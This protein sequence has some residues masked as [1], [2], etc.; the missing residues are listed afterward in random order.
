MKEEELIDEISGYLHIYL[1]SGRLHLNSFVKKLNTNVTNIQQLLLIRLLLKEE[2]K[3]FVCE[4]P[5]LLKYFKT[6]TH[7]VRNTN[8]GEVRGE[9]DWEQT[10]NK[11][12]NTNYKDTLLYVTT[13]SNRSYDTSENLVLKKLL[14]ILYQLTYENNYIQGFEQT[15]WFNDWKALK[16]HIEKALREN[17]YIQRVPERFVSE[18][19][20]R[21]T[22]THRYP[23][24]R[25]AAFILEEYYRIMRGD[26][27]E[28]ELR[29]LLK[30]TF[31]L[32]NNKDVLFELY[33]IIKIIKQN[34]GNS[35]LYLLDG[36]ENLVA[37]WNTSGY[38]YYI[39]HD[40]TGSTDLKFNIMETELANSD[41]PYT[42]QTYQSFQKANELS[43]LL[44]D[45]KPQRIFR[46][47]RPDFIIEI[48]KEDTGKLVH[49][50][51]GEVKNTS[52]RNY[53]MR[54]MRELLDYIYLVQ[55]VKG[56]Y[57]RDSTLV[58][59]LLCVGDTEWNRHKV[60]Q[61]LI[62]IA[63]PGNWKQINL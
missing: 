63:S 10:I 62:K 52:D 42:E 19:M 23:L 16:R 34:T 39:Y 26:Y 27:T 38:R 17:I 50:I 15:E 37:S 5:T 58:T 33:W 24:Y 59:G 41:H 25:R 55:D 31:I 47:G 49:L 36:Q 8:Y 61:T 28:S 56:N 7:F 57:L 11:R 1:K 54:G 18:R 29:Q 14:T 44:F 43:K 45:Q 60:D 35:Q 3:S 30:E 9:I 20:I 13:E 22:S 32:P 6:T 53:A 46:Q 4:L 51:I 2:T 48:R 21:K 12:L 40:S